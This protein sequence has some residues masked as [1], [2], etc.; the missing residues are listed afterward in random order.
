MSEIGHSRP[1]FVVGMN[2]SGTTMMLDLLDSHPGL[3]GF[4]R[5]TL[6]IPHYAANQAKYGDLT[7]DDNYRRLW[8]D[9]LG[10][11]V[12]KFVNQ[13]QTPPLPEDW[14]DR[15][16]TLAAV[17]D[18]TYR[19]FAAQQDK[20]RWC[21][22]TP[23]HV[24]HIDTLHG[25]FPEASFIHMV[26]DGRSCAASLHRRWKYHPCRSML[27]WKTLV[28]MARR[29]AD[30][31]GATYL[32]VRY[33]RLTADPEAVMREVCEF[34]GEGWDAGVLKTSRVRTFTGTEQ[35]DIVK[36]EATWANYLGPRRVATLERIGGRLLAELGYETADPGGDWTPPAWRSRLWTFRDDVYLAF[37]ALVTEFRFRGDGRW[38]SFGNRVRAAIRQRLSSRS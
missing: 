14:Q 35:K 19:I 12:F 26:R 15:P 5:E 32:E 29:Q 20:V 17:V 34:L 10:S 13:G 2:G 37:R 3:Y 28:P 30:A 24:Q 27:R 16:R 21:E 9:F 23:M 25:L 33:E 36:R 1:V 38:D 11:P 6:I 4:R 8:R 22:K 31:S 7:D 18:G